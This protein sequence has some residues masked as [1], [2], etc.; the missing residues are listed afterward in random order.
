MEWDFSCELAE[1]FILSLW[2]G[3]ELL[4]V[5]LLAK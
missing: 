4:P 2:D 5:Y 1:L 3:F